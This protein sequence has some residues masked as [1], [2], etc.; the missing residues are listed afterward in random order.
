[1]NRTPIQLFVPHFRIDESLDAVRTCMERGWTGLGFMTVDIEQKWK[2]YTGVKNA[3]FV[4][5]NTAGLHLALD[6]LKRRRGWADGDEVITTALT[7]VSTN[8]AILY[9]GLT[10]VFADVDEYLCIDPASLLERITDKT[11]AVMFVGIGGNVG[12]YLEVLEI[13]RSRGIAVILDA[14]HMAGT[15]IDGHH[16]GPEADVAVFSFQAVKNLPTADSGM[17]CFADD[18]DDALARRLSWLGISKDTY[19]RTHGGGAYKWMYDVD[20]LGYKYNGNSI[21]AA[22]AL[23]ALKYLD[24]DNAERRRISALYDSLLGGIDGIERVPMSTQ[25]VP[26]RHLYQVRVADRDRVMM[27]LNERS[28]FAGVHYRDNTEYGVFAAYPAEVPHTR[29]ASNSIISLPLHLGLSDEDVRYVA[30]SLI[31]SVR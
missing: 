4:N 16:V 25:C 26:S 13:C 27:D 15:R 24:D 19:E 6:V 22:L 10:P 20:E 3:H 9:C 11:R 29:A 31:E 18:A 7:F 23:V 21:M 8:H 1:M 12:R 17:V 2:E 14:A 5:S 30:E 28:V